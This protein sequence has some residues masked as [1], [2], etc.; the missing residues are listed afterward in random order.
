MRA[1]SHLF[2][3]LT[4]GAHSQRMIIVVNPGALVG[5]Q[6]GRVVFVC[7]VGLA[8]RRLHHS[9]TDMDFGKSAPT[10]LALI[11]YWDVIAR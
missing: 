8:W 4:P 6:V 10:L 2:A 3:C 5:G 11:I 7:W 1:E 9:S